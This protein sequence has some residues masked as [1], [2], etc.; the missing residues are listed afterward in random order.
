MVGD[1]AM[2]ATLICHHEVTDDRGEVLTRE[3][4][5]RHI[6]ELDAQ[7]RCRLAEA[8]GELI[9]ADASKVITAEV[10]QKGRE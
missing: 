6:G 2:G 10:E 3:G 7:Y 5:D 4:A 1:I 8:L 9:A